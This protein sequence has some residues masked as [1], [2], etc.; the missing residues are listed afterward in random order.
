MLMPWTLAPADVDVVDNSPAVWASS[1]SAGR[2]TALAWPW[3]RQNSFE[4]VGGWAQ[5]ATLG[6]HNPNPMKIQEFLLKF[7]LKY[8]QF[9]F[10]QKIL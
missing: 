9:G 7:V 3:C 1:S 5:A 6:M 8:Y 10:P 4:E 2:H